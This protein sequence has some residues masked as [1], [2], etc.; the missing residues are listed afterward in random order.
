MLLAFDVGNTNLHLGLWDGDAWA[1]SWR[2]RSVPDKMADEYAVLVRN[3]LH[4]ANV[5]MDAIDGVVIGSVVPSLTLTFVEL[6]ERYFK[7]SPVVVS[8]KTDN[9]VTL[10]ID[11]PQQAGA[12]RIANAAAIACLHGGGPAFVVDFGT[13]TNFDVVDRHNAYCGGAICPGIGVAH[14]AL[15]SRAAR[16]HK[17]DLLPP[18]SAVGR[19]TIHAM[20]SGIFLGYLGM[21]EGLVTR[22][23]AQMMQDDSVIASPDEIRVFATGGL[24]R[25]F[26]PH[27]NVFDRI[28]PELTL[29][30]LRVIHH[31]NTPA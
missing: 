18:P 1:L 5:S 4:S 29:D 12:D 6:V 27:T 11:Q 8:D 25:V 28:E 20:Q 15:V 7:F 24:A 23:K 26:Q 13:S 14:D 30:G 22:I 3:F 9:G 10:A 19:N 21:I 31:L 16:L 17:I 2:A